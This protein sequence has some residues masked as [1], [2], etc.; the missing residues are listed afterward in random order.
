MATIDSIIKLFEDEFSSIKEKFTIIKLLSDGTDEKRVLDFKE[1]HDVE[2][3]YVHNPGVYVFYGNGSPYRVGRHL[4]NTRL[5]VMQHIKGITGDKKF[6]ILQLND[7][8]DREVILFNLIELK[9]KHWAAALEIFLEESLKD[10]LKI[11][12]QRQG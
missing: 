7:F 5:R 6:N 9:N 2:L 8:P 4:T 3:D 12:A 1:I 11:P 10:D